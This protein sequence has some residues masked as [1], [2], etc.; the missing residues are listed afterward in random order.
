[1]L[2]SEIPRYIWRYR[3]PVLVAVA[4]CVAAVWAIVTV[5]I[6]PDHTFNVLDYGAKGDGVTDDTDA[7]QRAV[8]AAALGG[9]TVDFPAGT[10]LISSPVQLKSAVNL[11]GVTNLSILTMP[12]Q[13]SQTFMLEGWGL[14]DVTISGLTFRGGGY[15]ENASGIYM[16]GA[17]NCQASKLRFEALWYGMKLGSGDIG[18]GWVI[19]D[20][21]ARDCLDP[22]YVS[23][24]HDSDFTRLDLQAVNMP[25][26]QYHAMYLERECR[27]LTFSDCTLSGGSGYTLHLWLEGG[28]SSDLTFTGLTLDSTGGRY[29]LVIGSGFSRVRF[30]S[31]TIRAG[32]SGQVVLFYGGEDITFEGFA[33]SG[34]EVLVRV[35]GTVSDILMR[36]GSYTG[37]DLGTGVTFQNVT[38]A[39]M[40][41][42]SLSVQWFRTDTASPFVLNGTL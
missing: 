39:V 9:G 24:V 16:V 13:S 20:I 34:G 15:A 27:R 36:N 28:S 37:T 38:G 8:D 33:A 35:D 17:Q 42:G 21:V 19:T 31:S 2:P 23:H 10:F 4:V 11:R 18:R 6:P 12:A 22:L 32:S 26:N 7:I 25:S 1:L 5:V 40:T 14:S 41:T 30:V 29:P 3:W